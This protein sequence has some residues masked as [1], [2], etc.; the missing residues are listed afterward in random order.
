M[1]SRVLMRDAIHWIFVA[2]GQRAQL[3]KSSTPD[4]AITVPLH[5]PPPEDDHPCLFVPFPD[6]TD[7]DPAVQLGDSGQTVY[8]WLQH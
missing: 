2:V 3:A 4:S 5:N 7:R 1:L 6:W 8:D